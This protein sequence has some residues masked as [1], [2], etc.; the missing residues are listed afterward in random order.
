MSETESTPKKKGSA[1]PLYVILMSVPAMII[2]TIVLS[3]NVDAAAD[4]YVA[5]V[6]DGK[7]DDAYAM[8]ASGTQAQIS[9]EAFET[10]LFTPELQRIDEP[11]WNHTEGGDGRACVETLVDV[12]G[13]SRY[14]RIYLLDEGDGYRVQTVYIY[15]G[16]APTQPWRCNTP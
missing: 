11:V 7:L 16:I 5:L 15:T 6:R 2:T 1:W 3:G 10:S 14:L 12:D 8:L 13:D 9:R 4:D